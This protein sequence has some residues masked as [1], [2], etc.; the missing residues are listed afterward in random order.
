M[1][2]NVEKIKEIVETLPIGF[3]AHARVEVQVDEKASTS[4][5]IPATREVFISSHLILK[6]LKKV[7][8]CSE[9]ELDRI[10]RGQ[11]YH[12]LSH[13]ILTPKAM[14]CGTIY[15][16]FEDERIETLLDDYFY[17]VDF[18]WLIKKVC[19]FDSLS[20]PTSATDNFFQIVRFRVGK[21]EFVKEVNRIVKKYKDLNWNTPYY[22]KCMNYCKEIEELFNAVKKDFENNQSTEEQFQEQ[23]SKAQQQ[24]GKFS[25]DIPQDYDN[26]TNTQGEESQENGQGQ[27]QAQ[28]EDKQGQAQGGDDFSHGKGAGNTFADTLFN[29]AFESRLD[30]VFYQQME[31]ILNSFSKKN[32]GG[33]AVGAYSGVFNPRSA[34][35]EDYR[36]FDR[37]TAVRSSN[38]YGT[39]HL[40]LF[41][42]NSG[43]F[44]RNAPLANQIIC[45]L[46]ELEKKYPF[47]SVDF[48]LCGDK[49]VRCEDRRKAFVSA[50]EGTNIQKG[51]DLVVN[52][53]QKANTMNYN[54][55]LYDGWAD[56]WYAPYKYKP[57]DLKNTTLILDESCEN[58]GMKVK[59]AKVIICKNY[60]SQLKEQILKTLQNA[61]R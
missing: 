61:L 6:T 21:E 38:R 17:N 4:Y 52:S 28:G 34:G 22:N 60:L 48:A 13:A 9:Q 41:I 11:V 29:N 2:V 56:S 7:P 46:S 44:D 8:N 24:G 37:K 12:E 50:S 31:N 26:P 15:N 1:K 5:F 33:G 47:F 39:F 53:M 42:D 10:I 19:D 43:S 35:R 36:F 40:N 30:T 51:A 58:D 25:A 20:Q 14:P 32:S 45:V 59:N 16:I 57:F 23:K 27:T 49:V 18:K 55:V 54:I 3:Y